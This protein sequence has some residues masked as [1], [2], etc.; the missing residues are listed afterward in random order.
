MIRRRVNFYAG[1]G[2]GKSTTAS[3]VFA[4]IKNKIIHEGLDVQVELV[5]E[6]IKSW[7]WEGRKPRGFDQV[8]VCAKQMRREEIPL[9][10]GVDMV[11]SDSPLLLQC[12]YAKKNDVPCWEH[13]VGMVEEF[14]KEYPS[15]H[16]FLERGDRPYVAKGRY[17][18]PEQARIMDNYVRSMLTLYAPFF[19]SVS[20]TDTDRIVEMI[21]PEIRSK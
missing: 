16:I 8:Y 11:I 4:A 19:T 2:V 13:L 17:E 10:N 3:F 15:I 21:M 5:Q 12:A 14:E 7:A 1:P 18:T 20:Y 9:R 6:Y